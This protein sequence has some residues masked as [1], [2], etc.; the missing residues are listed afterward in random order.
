MSS[1]VLSYYFPLNHY[2]G[3]VGFYVAQA[4]GDDIYLY[5]D[6]AECHSNGTNPKA[7]LHGLRQQAEVDT[8]LHYQ[9]GPIYTERVYNRFIF[10]IGFYACIFFSACQTL[11]HQEAPED[12]IT[13]GC[14][15]S[16]LDLAAENC[17]ARYRHYF[18]GLLK[19]SVCSKTKEILYLIR[20][21]EVS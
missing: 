2:R 13:S 7:I 8:Q 4:V 6:E 1:Q 5:D 12:T 9:V 19:H 21:P 14:L 16:R 20:G 11:S 18:T 17:V 3:I 10:A 15:P